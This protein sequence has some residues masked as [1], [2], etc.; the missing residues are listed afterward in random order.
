[1]TPSLANI[2]ARFAS[3]G[4]VRNARKRFQKMCFRRTLLKL[5]RQA[6]HRR[7]VEQ[8]RKDALE[9]KTQNRK[10]HQEKIEAARLKKESAQAEALSTSG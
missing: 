2:Q 9:R 3:S 1:M 10:R 5:E 7:F 8:S 6:N 4:R